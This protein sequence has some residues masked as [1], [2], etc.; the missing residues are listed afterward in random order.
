MNPR[1]MKHIFM[2]MGDPE[3]HEGLVSRS[4]YPDLGIQIL[5]SRSWY[6]DLHVV[7]PIP[8]QSTTAALPGIVNLNS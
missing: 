2:L 4:W 7:S 1:E 5:V 3:G 8:M 6:P